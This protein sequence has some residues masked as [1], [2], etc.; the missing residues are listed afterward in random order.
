LPFLTDISKFLTSFYSQ[1]QIFYGKDYGCSNF[2][3]CFQ[4]FPKWGFTTLIFCT[5]KRKCF[6]KKNFQQ[7]TDSLKF[8]NGNRPPPCYNTTG[9]AYTLYLICYHH[10]TSCLC[11]P[12]A[13]YRQ[14]YLL[15]SL[16]VYTTL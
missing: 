8:R 5:F 14:D 3:F 7:F 9:L 11:R 15:R 6:S 4:M 12:E 2:Y 13:E 10:G 1:L 16:S